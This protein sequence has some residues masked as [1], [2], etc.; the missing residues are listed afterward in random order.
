[1]LDLLELEFRL[2]MNLL[3]GVSEEHQGAL[4]NGTS[5]LLEFFIYIGY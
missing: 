4:K 1:M 2:V 3:T 5:H